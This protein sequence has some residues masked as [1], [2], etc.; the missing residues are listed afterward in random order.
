M[1]NDI[2]QITADLLPLFFRDWQN[3]K[4]DYP[5]SKSLILRAIVTPDFLQLNHFFLRKIL[6]HTDTG[7][8]R[9]QN[10]EYRIRK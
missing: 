3:N 9:P 10:K 2:K 8:Y 5:T 1:I 4:R 7:E 6:N